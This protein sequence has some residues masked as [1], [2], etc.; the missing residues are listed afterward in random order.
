MAEPVG[1]QQRGQGGAALRP[2]TRV[3]QGRGGGVHGAQVDLVLHDLQAG[4]DGGQQQEEPTGV[5]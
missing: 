4:A 1:A 5:E 3:F 2:P